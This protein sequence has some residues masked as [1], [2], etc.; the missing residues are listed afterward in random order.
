MPLSPEVAAWLNQHG[1]DAVHASRIGLERADDRT[2]LQAA[3]A[4]GR[5]VITADL[6]FPQLFATTHAKGPGLI[7]LRGGNY[8]ERK[9][10]ELVEH[11][12]ASLPCAELSRSIVVIDHARLRKIALPL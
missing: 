12:L 6:D 1:P 3:R 9:S 2:I 8:S 10:L 11:V 5:V 7:L 4:E